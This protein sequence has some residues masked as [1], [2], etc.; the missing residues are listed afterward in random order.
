MEKSETSFSRNVV[1]EAKDMINK[2]MDFKTVMT[3]SKYLGLPVVFG[4]SRRKLL[5][6]GGTCVEEGE[7]RERKTPIQNRKIGHYQ[8]RH[9]SLFPVMS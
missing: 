6:C 1:D 8:S 3:H 5:L 9:A 7:A 4:R 2:R